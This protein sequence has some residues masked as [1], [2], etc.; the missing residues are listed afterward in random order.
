M[1]IH[2]LIEINKD[3]LTAFRRY[4]K[5]YLSLNK[6]PDVTKFLADDLYHTMR[7][8]GERVTKKE[9]KAPAKESKP[10]ETKESKPSKSEKKKEEK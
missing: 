6:K 5:R 10:K 2:K 3:L 8:E 9:A 1:S 4:Y 7:L